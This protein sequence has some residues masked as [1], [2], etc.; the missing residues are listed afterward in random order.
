MVSSHLAAESPLRL[1]TKLGH[2]RLAGVHFDTP[3]RPRASTRGSPVEVVGNSPPFISQPENGS[4]NSGSED[5]SFIRGR[6][7]WPIDHI[8]SASHAGV[9]RHSKP[10]S[11]V[12][13]CRKHSLAEQSSPL[14]EISDAEQSM[15]EPQP[16]E[17]THTNLFGILASSA[18]FNEMDLARF[19]GHR[20]TLA[21]LTLR[22]VQYSKDLPIEVFSHMAHYLDFATYKSVRLTCRCWSAAF[23]YVRPLRL[24]LVYHLPAEIIKDVYGYLSLTDL[25]AARHT[26]QR[27]MIA[28]LEYR[29]LADWL[30][31]AG[32]RTAFM[33]DT[34][35]NESLGHPVGGEWRLSK[36]LATEC[37]L[38]P[39]WTGDGFAGSS[40]APF[41]PRFTDDVDV[42]DRQEAT[43]LEV[44]CTVDFAE[45]STTQTYRSDQSWG[46]R[47]TISAC[48]KFLLV[49]SCTVIHVYSISDLSSP[50]PR[51]EHGGYM[52]FLVAILCPRPVLAVSMD[53]SKD[54]YTI[55]ALLH[56]RV[57][58]IMDVPE[59][60]IMANRS[61]SSSPHSERDTRNVTEAWELKAS[62]TAT[63]TTSQR[64]RLPPTYT[65]V[66]HASPITQ[67]PELDQPSPI[68]IQ[69][70]PHTMY[71]NLCSKTSPPGSV[72][73]CPHRRCVAFGCS[74]G[75]ELHWQD[76][77]TGQEL[78]RWMELIGP[79]EYIHFL[80]LRTEDENELAKKLR[81]TSSRSG[82]TYYHD[83][84]SVDEAWDY[85]QCK[86]LRGVPLSDG[87]HL[88]YTDPATGD[89]CVGTGLHS[90][91]GRPK[92]VKKFLLEGP[93]YPFEAKEKWP[94]CYRAGTELAWGAR[95]VAGFGQQLYLFCVP[96]DL[97][98]KDTDP[99]LA[100]DESRYAQKNGITIIVGVKIGEIPDLM[101]LG[102]DASHGDLLIHALSTSVPAQT[103][104]IARYPRKDSRKRVVMKNG[105]VVGHGEEKNENLLMKA[106]ITDPESTP[107]TEQD[108][109]GFRATAYRRLDGHDLPFDGG[110]EDDDED[111][112]IEM[113]E[114]AVGDWVHDTGDAGFEDEGY[115][116]G[117]KN[118]ERADER[119]SN[120]A[121][122]GDDEEPDRSREGSWDVMELV[123][124]EVE[125]L[126]GA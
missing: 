13:D 72:A 3:L 68:P 47:F 17:R 112:E 48:G 24:P 2:P 123:R 60:A 36:R 58:L 63:P 118:A 77:R 35:R 8:E 29:L 89:L 20:D 27:W 5:E 90:A 83:P 6:S 75:I 88:L 26:C 107:R 85:E 53:T 84:I 41:H 91:L 15:K 109:F 69:F 56:D 126:C 70:V 11:T 105:R 55:A 106:Y 86:F 67:T 39:G 62:P 44:S 76:A 42:S 25:N 1:N 111:E 97:L 57:G 96:P 114:H 113:R 115:E 125:I 71:R 59:L 65:D 82:P 16:P 50:F 31:R 19:G 18:T 49:L 124:L 30:I 61:G 4:S 93:G 94:I 73:I 52:E 14:D 100:P 80:P 104:Q 103:Y 51:Y 46:L 21:T 110:E 119:S 45:L 81:M 120:D 9:D 37:S 10:T 99:N 121:A 34:L 98:R 87:K 79:A 32:F 108:S 117:D 74:A 23:T 43:S 40:P 33:A 54:R 12:A 101:E 7:S 28:S 64:P 78:S 92:P 95:I 22:R 102:V 116:S 38:T 66:Y 122:V